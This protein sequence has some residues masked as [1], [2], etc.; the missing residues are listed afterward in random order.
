MAAA[1]AGNLSTRW[2]VQLA[3]AITAFSVQMVYMF[4]EVGVLGSW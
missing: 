1:L 3:I 4:R 2:S